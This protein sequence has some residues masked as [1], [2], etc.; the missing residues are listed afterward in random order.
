MTTATARA[1]ISAFDRLRL[2]PPL[3][4]GS[5]LTVRFGWT[6]A[7]ASLALFRWK[8]RGLVEALGGKSDVF[9]NRLTG[10]T[11]DWDAALWM[12]MPSA[13][14]VGVEALRRGGVCTQIAPRPE[15][16]VSRAHPVFKVGARYQL[17]VRPKVW[18]AIVA[19]GCMVQPKVRAAVLRPEWAVADLEVTGGIERLRGDIDH[20]SLDVKA[21][22]DARDRLSRL[23]SGN[24]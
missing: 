15:V 10:G 3:F 19:R 17:A 8:A 2:L 14:I 20:D 22:N 5:D 7:A 9:A 4:K 13:V 16:A 24:A 6:S 18:F 23:P 12:A 1:Q 21:L 11:P